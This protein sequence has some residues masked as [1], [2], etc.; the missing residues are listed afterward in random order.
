MMKSTKWMSISK[1]TAC[2][3]GL[4]SSSLQGRDLR[5]IG[6]VM[7]M[8]T[9]IERIGDYAV[10]IAKAVRKIYHDHHEPPEVDIP[11]LSECCAAHASGR[12]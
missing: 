3:D 5:I 6:T 7:K 1:P 11:R 12:D 10:D 4:H 9:D 2:A 8:I